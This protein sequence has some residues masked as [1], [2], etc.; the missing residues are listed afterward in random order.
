MQVAA[1]S[2]TGGEPIPFETEK[3]ILATPAKLVDAYSVNPKLDQVFRAP[4]GFLGE[5][6]IAPFTAQL[7][8]VAQPGDTKLFLDTKA[9]LQPGDLLKIG[10]GD[11]ADYAEVGKPTE[12]KV[13]LNQALKHRHSSGQLV[14]KVRI[15]ELFEG[16]DQQAHILYLGHKNLF[17]IKDQATIQ[18]VLSNWKQEASVEHI[19][20]EYYGKKKDSETQN[21]HAFDQVELAANTKTLTLTKKNAN[22]LKELEIHGIKNNW[23]RG[24]VKPDQIENCKKKAV[25]WL[26]KCSLERMN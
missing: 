3:L 24:A 19:R 14:D 7:S 23:N 2:P 26:F 11:E 5:T 12:N 10:E 20:W 4:T 21:W 8:F 6:A 16:L 9:D 17:Q 1:N 18:L 22:E 13:E 15:F 25:F